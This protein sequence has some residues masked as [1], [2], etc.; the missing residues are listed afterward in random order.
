MTDAFDVPADDAAEPTMDEIALPISI[1]KLDR[2]ETTNFN[3]QG[4][5]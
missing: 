2:L 5:S 4:A 1:R 3:S